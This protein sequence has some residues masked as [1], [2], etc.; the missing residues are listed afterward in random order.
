MTN[1]G[2]MAAGSDKGDIYL[3]QINYQDI[4]QKKGKEVAQLIGTYK[5]HA[6]LSLIHI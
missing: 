3:W 6:K 5:K 4:K 2:L 1:T